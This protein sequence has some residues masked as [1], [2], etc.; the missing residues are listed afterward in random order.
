M[1]QAID[2]IKDEVIEGNFIH[3][4]KLRK[5]GVQKDGSVYFKKHR[6][7]LIV[8]RGYILDKGYAVGVLEG[9]R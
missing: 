1:R 5:L 7:D 3:K 2:F 4:G 8:Y 9:A 6:N